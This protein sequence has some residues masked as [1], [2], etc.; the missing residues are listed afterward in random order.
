MNLMFVGPCIIVIVEEWK[1][2]LISLAI[3]FHF[4]CAQ[5]V[6]DI[7]ISIIR[8]LRLCWCITTSV[9]LFSVYCVLELWCG[10]FWVVFVLQALMIWKIPVS[11]EWQYSLLNG[12]VIEFEL[13][14]LHTYIHTRRRT[15]IHTSV[16]SKTYIK[17]GYNNWGYTNLIFLSKNIYC[18]RRHIMS[19]Q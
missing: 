7:N 9:V 15:Y 10:W 19:L 2:N 5:H 17:C 16:S 3:L 8:S 6:S 18:I 1:T 11:I 4:L 13:V 14:L 12:T